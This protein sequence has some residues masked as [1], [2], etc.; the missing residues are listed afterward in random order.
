MQDAL[1]TF[2][3]SRLDRH[4]DV[5]IEEVAAKAL[6]DSIRSIRKFRGASG[7]E[8]R[9]FV[10]K[11]AKR[12]IVDYLRSNRIDTA[13]IEVDWGEGEHPHPEVEDPGVDGEADAVDTRLIIRECLDD[14]REDHRAVV[15][16]CVLEGRSA[17]ET[18]EMV[19]S[20]ID[21]RSD[22]SMSEQNVHQIVSRFRK[23]LRQR[24]EGTGKSS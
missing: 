24:L 10:F 9:A 19:N 13:P 6:E 14:L 8:A 12:R 3:R 7:K 22:D 15:E 18:T 17:R 2:V 4:G 5:V 1:L 23:D 16:L 20:R 21:G 11:I